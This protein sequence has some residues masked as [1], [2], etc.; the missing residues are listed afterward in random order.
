MN[1][2]IFSP[3]EGDIL[4]MHIYLFF[5]NTT[6]AYSFS[7]GTPPKSNPKGGG[8]VPEMRPPP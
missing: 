4:H 3:K 1:T 5:T 2:V 8:G 6:H 7:Y